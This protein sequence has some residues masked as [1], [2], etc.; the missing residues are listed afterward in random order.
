MFYV[1][2]QTTS[3]AGDKVS[4]VTLFHAETDAREYVSHNEDFY[5]A[6]KW[7]C[8]DAEKQAAMKK[9]CWNF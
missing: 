1:F 5:Y 6:F 4:C 8:G 9:G 3:Y 2:H 7:D